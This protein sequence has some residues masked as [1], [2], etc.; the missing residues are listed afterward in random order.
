MRSSGAD[1]A[2]LSHLDDA[3]LVQQRMPTT[4]YEGPFLGNGFLGCGIYAEPGTGATGAIHPPRSPGRPLRYSDAGDGAIRIALRKRDSALITARDDRPDLT[5]AP[6]R[7]NEDAPHWG[8]P[9]PWGLD[10]R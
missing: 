1:T 5:I 9:A 7:P 6:V 10:D 3:D 4:W 8:L 2:D